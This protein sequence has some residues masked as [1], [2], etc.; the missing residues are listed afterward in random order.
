MRHGLVLGLLL[1]GASLHAAP[2]RPPVEP[3]PKTSPK[4]WFAKRNGVA[5]WCAFSNR[6]SAEAALDSGDYDTN[7]G[8]TIWHDGRRIQAIMVSNDSEDAFADDIYYLN[9]GQRITRM[10]RTG[11][12]IKDPVFSVTFVPDWTARLALTP[13]SR[14]VLR[15]MEQAEFESYIADWPK[16]GS[17]E[18]MPFRSL[19]SL[20]PT[21]SIRRGCAPAAL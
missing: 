17:Y 19:I 12:Y 21:V 1:S 14:E 16:Y 9:A 11:H 15:L 13:A 18:T 2:Y 6:K 8:A 4:A 20:R 7:E 3:G 10:V 5:I